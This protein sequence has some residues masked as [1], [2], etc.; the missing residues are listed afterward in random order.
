V[1][2]IKK[3]DFNQKDF[4]LSYCYKTEKLAKK[5]GS[6]IF[7]NFTIEKNSN[8]YYVIKQGDY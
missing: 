8:N 1:S 4:F 7:K 3:R 6:K 2:R 5:I